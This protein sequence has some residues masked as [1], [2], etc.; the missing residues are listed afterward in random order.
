GDPLDEAAPAAA[1]KSPGERPQQ[2][3]PERP[4]S[5]SLHEAPPVSDE[6]RVVFTTDHSCTGGAFSAQLRPV[7]TFIS[8]DLFPGNYCIAS[9]AKFIPPPR[10]SSIVHGTRSWAT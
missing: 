7:S 10:S 6:V 8:P 1:R 9:A 3:L 4:K 5:F 2:R